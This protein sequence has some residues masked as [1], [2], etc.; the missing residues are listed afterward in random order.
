MKKK[1]FVIL[2]IILIIFTG[3]CTGYKPIFNSSSLMIEIKN[4]SIKGDQS[5]GK[6]MYMKLSNLLKSKG[7]ENK[8]CIDLEINITK[9]KESTI[10]NKSGKVLEYKIILNTN[11]IVKNYETENLIFNKKGKFKKNTLSKTK[12]KRYI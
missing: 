2:P 5:L 8:K 1:Y 3:G 7:K 10:K 12:N 4:Y 11:L 9:N 6:R